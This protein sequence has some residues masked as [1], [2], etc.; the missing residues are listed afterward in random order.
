MK[1]EEQPSEEKKRTW[2]DCGY[3]TISKSGKVLSVV[4]KHQRYVVN[5]EETAEVLDGKRNY[6]LIFEFVGSAIP[7]GI[8]P[9]GT[10][11]EGS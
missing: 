4:V 6:T 11:R 7:T 2:L 3:L 9:A 5:L 8:V 1:K 10:R